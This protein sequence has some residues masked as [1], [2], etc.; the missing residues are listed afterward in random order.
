MDGSPNQP[1]SLEGRVFELATAP[2]AR[3]AVDAAFDY[4]GDVTLELRSGRAV[5]GYVCNRDWTRGDGVVDVLPRFGG[6]SER[7]L[8]CDI[9][10]IT[11][12]GR[13]S[14]AGSSIR[15]GRESEGRPATR[16][17]TDEAA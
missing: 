6:P 1:P 4:R 11:L 8:V 13:D 10:R 15:L 9:A 17:Y 3:E 12:T 5:V 16:T 14:A 7:I 2:R